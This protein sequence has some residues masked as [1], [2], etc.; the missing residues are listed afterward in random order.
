MIFTTKIAI[1]DETSTT[2]HY[3]QQVRMATTQKKTKIIDLI[4]KKMII[5]NTGMP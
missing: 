1:I 2:T 5:T 4:I 3:H